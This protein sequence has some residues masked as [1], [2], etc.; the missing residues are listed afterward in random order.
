M[1]LATTGVDAKIQDIEREAF[2]IQVDDTLA[3]Y[4]RQM[5]LA[6][7]GASSGSPFGSETGTAEKSLGPGERARATE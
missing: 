7:E 5:G 3:A 6:T 1:D 2:N 4:K